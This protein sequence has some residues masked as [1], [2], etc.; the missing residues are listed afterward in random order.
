MRRSTGPGVVSVLSCVAAVAGCSNMSGLT[1]PVASYGASNIMSPA[2]YSQTMVDET[3][4]KVTAT[5]TEATPPERV[6]KIARAR[7]AQIGVDQKFNY[8]KVAGVEHG[9][10]CSKR[11]DGYKSEPTPAT[12]RPK[13]VLDVVYA[14]AASDP[15][16]TDSKQAFDSLSAE[17]ASEVV[18]PEAKAAAIQEARKGCGQS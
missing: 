12:S 6:E 7:A 10:E 14:K 1:Q 8:F 2:G 15:T 11:Q 3:H 4:F 18:A 13:V 5:G 9:V 17:L 16:F